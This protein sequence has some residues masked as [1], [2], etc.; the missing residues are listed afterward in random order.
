MHAVEKG[1]SGKSRGKGEFSDNYVLD[2]FPIIPSNVF[3]NLPFAGDSNGDGA[4]GIFRDARGRNTVP[5]WAGSVS[6]LFIYVKNPF[7]DC[8][9]KLTGKTRSREEMS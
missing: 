1:L 9:E 7:N 5:I 6:R 4:C 2:I 3:D 8:Y